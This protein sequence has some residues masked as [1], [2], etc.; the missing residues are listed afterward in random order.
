MDSVPNGSRLYFDVGHGVDPA[1]SALSGQDDI[2]EFHVVCSTMRSQGISEDYIKMKTFSCTIGSHTFTY[3]MLNLG[4]SINVMP[5][6]IYKSLNLGDLELTRM[7]IQLAN[8][9]VVQ[10]LGVLKDVLIQDEASGEGSALILGRPYF[11]TAKKKIDVHAETLSMEFGDTYVK[12]NIFEALKYPTEYHSIFSIDAIDGLME[13]YF[14][15]GTSSASLVDFVNIS[16]EVRSDSSQKESQQTEV[17]SNSRHMKIYV[18]PQLQTTELKSLPE[19]LKYAYLGENQ[20][21]LVII[22]NNL[23]REQEEK[24]LEVHRKHKKAIGWTLAYLSGINPSKCM[25]KILLE[26]DARP[27]RQQQQ[28]LNLTLL[29]VVKKEVTKP[30]I[31]GI[32]YSIL[33]RQRVSPVQVVPKKSKMMVIKNPQDEMMLAKIQNNWRVCF[34]YRK[35]NQATRNDHFPLLF[36]NQVLEKLVDSHSTPRSIQDYLHMYIRNVRIYKDVVLTLQRSK[37]FSEMH[38]QHLLR[39]LGGLHGGIVLGHLVSARGIEVDKAKI[40]V[41]SSL[42]NPSYVRFIKDFNKIALPLSKLLQK[43]TDFVFDQPCVVAFQ[44]L[45]KTHVRA[46]PPSTKLGTSV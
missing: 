32:I 33:D 30:L 3:A 9:S 5:A 39:P 1:E 21:F 12:F 10:P 11:M 2:L 23:S 42:S 31:V 28:R 41:I 45:K 24:L 18:S 37:H 22:A 15:L 7:E 44:E 35:L 40:D 19:H 43:D 36:V 20:Q 38:D 27:V 13:E 16:D 8:R 34:D 14:R 4:A 26:E 6:L 46:H 29:H 25:Q 17:E